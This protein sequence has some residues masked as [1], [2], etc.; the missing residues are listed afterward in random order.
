M[1][2]IISELEKHLNAKI[3]STSSIG[4]GCIGNS[5]KVTSEEG[6]SYFVKQYGNN[7]MYRAE[8]NG[9]KELQ[10]SNAIRV[11]KVVCVGSDFLCLEFIESA[12]EIKNF[13]GVFGQQFAQMHKFS[14]EKFGFFENNFI[15]STEN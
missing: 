5:I 7:E 13:K 3:V 10:K 14:L 15:G 2:K 1:K 12:S 4:G 11:P 9:L 8:S 6:Q